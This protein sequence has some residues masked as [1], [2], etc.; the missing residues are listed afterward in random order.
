[1]SM[2][3]TL[4]FG[5]TARAGEKSDMVARKSAA[6][7]T[8]VVAGQPLV[9]TFQDGEQRLKLVAIP[10]SNGKGIDI[11]LIYENQK[12]VRTAS[13]NPALAA[14]TDAEALRSF[15]GNLDPDFLSY[16]RASLADRLLLLQNQPGPLE[17]AESALL[18]PNTK[19]G[20]D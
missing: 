11:T 12:V 10:A 14:T 5:S 15:L 6:P 20:G 3:F 2:A 1:M 16:I 8:A 9:D 17:L 18:F 4:A 19:D 7:S 13:I